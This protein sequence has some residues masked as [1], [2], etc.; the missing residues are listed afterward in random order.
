MS[1]CSGDGHS[2]ALEVT[3]DPCKVTYEELLDVFY[4]NHDYRTSKSTQYKSALFPVSERQAAQAQ[5]VVKERAPLGSRTVIEE[6]SQQ[7]WT[8]EWYHQKHDQKQRVQFALLAIYVIFFLVQ[9]I[10]GEPGLI[11]PVRVVVFWGLIAS[12]APVI[13]ENVWGLLRTFSMQLRQ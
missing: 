2:E 4:R 12:L 1:V 8:A 9:D 13:V 6:P 10:S 11:K 5:E 7:F 3:Y